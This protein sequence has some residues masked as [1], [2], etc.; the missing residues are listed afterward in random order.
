MK[1]K[2]KIQELINT[3]ISS[4][5]KL[6][7]KKKY[8]IKYLHPKIGWITLI[9]EKTCYDDFYFKN[10]EFNT[11]EVAREFL[12]NL[13]Y[14]DSKINYYNDYIKIIN[15]LYKHFMFNK[16]KF[17]YF[18]CSLLVSIFCVLFLWLKPSW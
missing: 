4:D 17:I 6:I 11:L 10:I 14:T 8:V 13:K 5:A 7:I 9:E 12:K 2:Y 16:F 1:N 18:I 3:H 15:G